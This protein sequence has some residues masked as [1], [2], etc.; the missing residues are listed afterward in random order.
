MTR[1]KRGTIANKRRKNVL[2]ETKGF[3]WQRGK[4]YKSAKEALTRARVHAYRDRKKKKRTQRA[5][6]QLK[7]NEAC[8]KQGVSY[9]K[10][11]N[12]LKK[13]NI[14]IDRKILADLVENHSDIFE[15]LI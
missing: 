14:E 4:K 11:I 2:K 1:V 5:L 12:N 6:W 15:K 8:K 7:I 13:Q 10:F 3:R 9:N